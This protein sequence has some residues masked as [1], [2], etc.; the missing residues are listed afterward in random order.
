FDVSGGRARVLRLTGDVERLDPALARALRPGLE[1]PPELSGR[2]DVR[3]LP[4]GAL[5]VG[6]LVRR[7]TPGTDE[8]RLRVDGTVRPGPEPRL[9]LLVEPDAVPL[10]ALTGKDWLAGALGGSVRVTGT[11]P[12]LEVSGQVTTAAGPV[13]IQSVLDLSGEAPRY[14]GVF[15]LERFAVAALVPSLPPGELTGRVQVEGVGLD[16]ATAEVGVRASLAHA[17]LGALDLRSAELR[18]GLSDGLMRVDTLDALADAG[19]MT[20]TG[21]LGLAPGRSGTLAWRVAAD[22]LGALQPFLF[23]DTLLLAPGEER[24]RLGGRVHAEGRLSGRLGALDLQATLRASDLMVDRARTPAARLEVS[25]T[26]LGGPDA[27]WSANLDVERLDAYG[28][29]LTGALVALGEGPDGGRL[30]VFAGATGERGYQ[31]EGRFRR[32]PGETEVLLDLLQ[33]RSRVAAWGLASPVAARLGEADLVLERFE[34]VREGGT[35]RIQAEGALPWGTAARRAA[36][37]TVLLENVRLAEFLDLAQSDLGAEGTMTGRLEVSGPAAAPR[38]QADITGSRLG[39][40]GM[41][42]DRAYFVAG[43]A[44]RLLQAR[45]EARHGQRTV[46]SATARVPLDL[47]LTEVARRRLAAAQE[48]QVRADSL[49]LALFT[50]LVRGF[51][52]V[53]GSL[54]GDMVVGGTPRAPDMSGLFRIADGELAWAATGVR[55][56]ALQGT[57]TVSGQGRVDV[58]AHALA[59]PG[60]ADIAGSVSLADPADPGL[61]LALAARDFELTRRREVEL[62]G[63]ADL[64]LT[65]SYRSPLVR[66]RAVVTAGAVNLDEIWRTYQVVELDDDLLFSVVDTTLVSVRGL[67]RASQN[68]FLQNLVVDATVGVGRDV[69]LRSR[70]MNVEIAG[71]LDVDLDR[72]RE[73]LRVGGSLTALRGIYQL[74][75]RRFEVQSGEVEFVGTPGL[76]PNLRIT[77][78]YRA[79]N[80]NNQPLDINAVVTGTLLSPRVALTSQ[81]EPPISESDLASYLIFGRP[82][83]ALGAAEAEAARLGRFGALGLGAVGPSLIGFAGTNLETFAQTL[84]F[85]DY[86]ALTA[87]ELAAGTAAEL[88]GLASLFP[89]ARFTLGWYLSDDVFLALSQRVTGSTEVQQPAV[90]MEWRFRPTWTLEAFSEDRF[91]NTPSLGLQSTLELQRVY[92]VFLFRE[93]GY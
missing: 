75:G 86:L 48:V 45:V 54:T 89:A 6:G 57:L 19:R 88:G 77:A 30:S 64:Q 3:A 8:V 80:A 59:G 15:Q 93:W 23:P 87:D 17:R 2:L 36:D 73:A 92:G 65:G 63:T 83:Y 74:Y 68:P 71:E 24:A 4:G 67:V 39:V 51:Q 40:E 70:Q 52:D 31:L 55:Y 21:A 69:W 34:L 58:A 62:T 49:P 20:A 7:G 18:L 25:A 26:A 11:L 47:A 90:R 9:D 43:Y 82:T 12:A 37:F 16:P 28:V 33:L 42:L 10:A 46:L 32:H 61:D 72:R 53:S 27:A 66:G 1:L 85:A 91:A 35:G 84:G 13:R 38:I 78:L 14:R 22:S 50:S 76:D 41:M 56:R 29:R 79:R 44:D 5:A 81:A 60:Y